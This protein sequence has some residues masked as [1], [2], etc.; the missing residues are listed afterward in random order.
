[1]ASL[2]KSSKASMVWVFRSVVIVYVCVRE[3]ES[4]NVPKPRGGYR[5]G[6]RRERG[7]IRI[8]EEG[9]RG[10]GGNRVRCLW[11][12]K[13]GQSRGRCMI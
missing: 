11:G 9:K 4:P 13:S 5:R 8:E 1:M 10:G 3:I 6:V 2:V 7:Y 12:I